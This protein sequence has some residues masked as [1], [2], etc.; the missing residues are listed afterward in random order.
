MQGRQAKSLREISGDPSMLQST[1][2]EARREIKN[3]VKPIPEGLETLKYKVLLRKPHFEIREY[4]NYSIC[5]TE[6]SMEEGKPFTILA[7][8]IFGNANDR[9]EKL[10]MTTPV[11][12]QTPDIGVD[13]ERLSF[14]LSD[15]KTSANAPGP[16]DSRVKIM[17]VPKEVVAYMEFPGIATMKENKL[18][19]DLLREYL[20]DESIDFELSSMKVFQY[21]PPYTLPWLR[22]N[23]VLFRVTGSFL[24]DTKVDNDENGYFTSPEAGD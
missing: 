12:T 16:T 7:D 13:I 10:S 14:V 18:Q 9:S 20:K 23:A 15:R 22:T 8:Y 3:I 2:D 17:D 24:E 6:E 1:L 19:S 11:I 4:E 21:N 5:S